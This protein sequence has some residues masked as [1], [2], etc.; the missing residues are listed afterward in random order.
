MDN[1]ASPSKAC[2]TLM[3][4]L[5][6]VSKYGI[7]PLEWQKVAALLLEIYCRMHQYEDRGSGERGATNYSFALFDIDFVTQ[8]H[9][10]RFKLVRYA[11][12]LELPARLSLTKGKFSGSRGEA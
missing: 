10:F 9:L 12:R 8:N 3:A 2:S 1:F 7:S 11:S 5:A 4:S 6:L